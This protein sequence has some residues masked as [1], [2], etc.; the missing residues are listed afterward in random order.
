MSSVPP[1]APASRQS[2]ITTRV[3]RMRVARGACWVIV[4]ALVAVAALALVDALSPLPAWQRGIGLAA[5]LTGSGV[6]VWRLVARRLPP[7][8]STSARHAKTELPDNLRAA[9]AAAVALAASLGAATLVPGAGEHIRRVTLPWTRTGGPVL[10]RVK[11][12]AGEPV[13]GRGDSVTLSAYVEKV[14]P[15]AATPS[16]ATLTW[17]DGDGREFSLAMSGD[18]TGAFHATRPRVDRSFEYRVEVGGSTSDWYSVFVLD[19]VEPTGESRIEIAPPAYAPPESSRPTR[20]LGPIEGHQFATAAL[21]LHFSQPVGAAFLE[22]R[23]QDI[24]GMD[25]V[26]ISL[27]PERRHGR[28]SFRL[29]R[30]GTLK[31]VTVAEAMGR[32]LRAEFPIPVRVIPDTPPRFE[33]ISG[34]STRPRKART[35]ARL[36]IGF[37]ATDDLAVASARLE[38]AVG[39]NGIAVLPVAVAAS[40]AGRAT[41]RIEF[42]V[43]GKVHAGQSL[44]L[45]L[46]IQD[47]RRLDHPDLAPQS[48]RYPETGWSIV[49]IDPAAPPLDEQDILAQRNAL[50]DALEEALESVKSLQT[51]VAQARRETAGK[52]ELALDQ[53]VRLANIRDALR[54]AADSLRRSA[55]EAALTREIRTLASGLAHIADGPLR[56]AEQSVARAATNSPADRTASLSAAIDTLGATMSALDRQLQLNQRIARARLDHKAIAALA[57][58]QTAVATL[59]QPGGAIGSE[60]LAR[61]ERELHARLR[62]LIAESDSLREA[63]EAARQGEARRLGIALQ[64]LAGLVRDLDAASKHLVNEARRSLFVDAARVQ[65]RLAARVDTLLTR[66]ARAARVAGTELPRAKEFARLAALI[67]AGRTVEALTELES[68]AQSLDTVAAALDQWATN[69]RDP[70]QAARQLAAWQENLRSRFRAAT[71]DNPANYVKL[72]DALK[73]EF[74]QE[75]LS[76]QHFATSFPIPRGLD[77]GSLRRELMLRTSAAGDFKDPARAVEFMASAA[78]TFN[79]LAD[80]IPPIPDRLAKARGD[81]VPHV[82]AQETLFQDVEQAIRSVDSA[83]KLGSLAE[84]QGRQAKAFSGL[85]L[86]GLESR[87]EV[88]ARALGA[89]ERDLRAGLAG[90]ALASQQWVRRE[91]DRLRLVLDG[92]KAPDDRAR[93]LASKL[94]RLSRS[95]RDLG[96]SFSQQ[97]LEAFGAEAMDLARRAAQAGMPPEAPALA[98]EAHSKAVALEAAA[99]DAVLKPGDFQEQLRSAAIALARLSARLDS[100][101]PDLDRVRRLASSRWEDWEGA[102]RV[103]GKPPNPDASAESRRQLGREAEELLHTRAGF[104]GQALK[105]AILEQYSRLKDHD[106]PDRQGGPLR[107]LAQSLDELA[108][109]MADVGELSVPFDRGSAPVA[110]EGGPGLFIPTP[111]KAA[112][113]RELAGQLRDLRRRI[114][115]VGEEAQALLKPG[116]KNSIA[117]LE[118]DQ[119]ALAAAITALARRLEMET[120]DAAKLVLEAAIQA[121]LAA[122]GLAVGRLAAAG[123]SAERAAE[124]LRRAQER[125]AERQWAPAVAELLA[126]QDSKRS[127]MVEL[128]KSAAFS[129]IA[130]QI[131]SRGEDLARRAGELAKLFEGTARATSL[132][133][134][135]A[136]GKELGEVQSALDEATR[137][138]ANGPQ[139]ESSRL[140]SEAARRMVASADSLK[141]A[142]PPAP[143]RPSVDATTLKAAEA[144]ARADLAMREALESLEPKPDRAAAAL[145]MREAATALAAAAGACREVFGK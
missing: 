53:T 124:Q 99:R 140:R 92:N 23:A 64:E 17:R 33:E 70:K 101:E 2:E 97:Q 129:E 90:D 60:E 13:V 7:D 93:E 85:D 84:R 31:L 139:A 43:S 56:L 141:T 50:G 82:A 26:P 46:V 81:F 67:E 105:K 88:V 126:R 137:R 63:T 11:V 54:L 69:H 112:A 10:Y 42:D 95:V 113:L 57:T 68:R 104:A 109:L 91:F 32:T 29:A 122:D 100:T 103:Q 120:D 59:S 8:R 58:D 131:K 72:T 118:K 20:A 130:A 24:P 107:S 117:P 119:R 37:T 5:W 14:K 78:E 138:D 83:R 3:H 62:K 9:A 77:L 35:D 73:D 123:S 48:A 47:G 18:G 61:L 80:A 45:R 44:R 102:R 40:G 94:E 4:A 116:G 87:A 145:A 39:E 65:T 6:L 1:I 15:T 49:T 142:L 79:R 38:Y 21:D 133:E 110:P 34:L 16:E 128:A 71:N 132:A 106:A 127:V 121:T 51:E 55:R 86:P 41:G 125:G 115:R 135:A 28:A 143:A 108:A 144:L 36:A 136:A 30:A 96:P 89:A 76:I 52:S 27:D 114:A 111:E 12:T 25:L 98:N 74:R 19:P 66:T 22:W 134:L 75:Q